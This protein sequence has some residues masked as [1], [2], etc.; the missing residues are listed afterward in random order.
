[1]A[2]SSSVETP[3]LKHLFAKRKDEIS[4]SPQFLPPSL[5]DVIIKQKASKRRKHVFF[6][7]SIEGEREKGGKISI[8]NGFLNN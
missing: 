1:M 4:I 7:I 3:G 6:D 2:H 8:W 5:G